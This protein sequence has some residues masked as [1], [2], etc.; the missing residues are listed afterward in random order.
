MPF[1]ADADAPERG[2][3]RPRSADASLRS[4]WQRKKDLQKL[5]A[6]EDADAHRHYIRERR[7]ASCLPP[8]SVT[9]CSPQWV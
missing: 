4:R 6:S 3:F 7:C 5:Q 2:V 1:E 9:T 8:R